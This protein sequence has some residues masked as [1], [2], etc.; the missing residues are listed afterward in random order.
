MKHAFVGP[1]AWTTGE[2]NQRVFRAR[3]GLC[4]A[5]HYPA[6]R[7]AQHVPV[8][9]VQPGSPGPRKQ[10]SP[11]QRILRAVSLPELYVLYSNWRGISETEA[12]ARI[13][14]Y[15]V[16]AD[17]SAWDARKVLRSE[18]KFDPR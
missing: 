15:R 4:E 13:L 11:R 14:R 1:W 5:R 10:P 18:P 7:H 2:V 9:R 12:E 17:G 8:L 3:P 6:Y 16:V